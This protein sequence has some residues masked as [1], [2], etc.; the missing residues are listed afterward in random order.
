VV[1]PPVALAAFAAAPIA[2]SQPMETGFEASRLAIAGFLIPFLFCYHPSLL[3]IDG[4]I[5]GKLLW[6]LGAFGLS[7]WM[8]ATGLGGFETRRLGKRARAVRVVAGLV[9]LTPQV[10]VAAPAA[11]VIVLI[12]VLHR[13][14]GR[15]R[16][17]LSSHH[18]EETS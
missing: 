6:A 7:T 9:V 15:R 12:V 2:G 16:M 13:L 8:L 4:V 1:T 3:L 17:P 5:P 11:A 18:P 14:S 10:T